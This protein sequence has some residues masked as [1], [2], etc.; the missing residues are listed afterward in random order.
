V[1]VAE[2][3]REWC[4]PL[5]PAAAPRRHQ[6]LSG[7]GG[8]DPYAAA[9]A[10]LGP[11]SAARGPLAEASA[12]AGTSATP[13]ASAS[14]PDAAAVA[15]STAAAA[16]ASAS[17]GSPDSL[18]RPVSPG[19][20]AEDSLDAQYDPAV[21][22][23]AAAAAAAGPSGVAALHAGAAVPPLPPPAAEA[24]ELLQQP[25]ELGWEEG[26]TVRDVLPRV[27]SLAGP[28]M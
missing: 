26:A 22:A 5:P 6:Q 27:L 10:A 4:A 18:A 21:E 14:A 1:P 24:R 17:V 20:T 7:R 25:R 2:Q 13:D 8:R 3:P 9:T 12:P 19:G 11:D 23:A 28:L 15:V 16:G